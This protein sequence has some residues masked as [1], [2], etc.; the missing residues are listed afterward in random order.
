MKRQINN[1]K[2]RLVIVKWLDQMKDVNLS[3]NAIGMS[4]KV[5]K[6]KAAKVTSME[7]DIFQEEKLTSDNGRNSSSGI[8]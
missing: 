2:K 1:W 5:F 7:A 8:L 6:K 4:R 3:K